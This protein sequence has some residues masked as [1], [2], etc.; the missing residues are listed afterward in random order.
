KGG[1]GEEGEEYEPRPHLEAMVESQREAQPL[2][3]RDPLRRIHAE[4]SPIDAEAQIGEPAAGRRQPIAGEPSR[5]VADEPRL[6]GVPEHHQGGTLEREQRP[7][8]PV[9]GPRGAVG[10]G[11]RAGPADS[12][13]GE[14]HAA[15]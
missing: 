7:S 10:P 8:P 5:P 15:A 6:P 4:P 13:P 12:P 11:E 2:A 3:R 14:G 1:T 9:P